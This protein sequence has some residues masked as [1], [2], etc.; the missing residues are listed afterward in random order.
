MERFLHLTPVFWSIYFDICSCTLIKN[1][2]G[3]VFHNWPFCSTEV[4][5]N[6]EES[7]PL[8]Q[9]DA[10]NKKLLPLWIKQYFSWRADIALSLVFYLR[11]CSSGLMKMDFKSEHKTSDQP[12]SYISWF[13][14]H[15]GHIRHSVF[16]CKS[17]GTTVR[18]WD[19]FRFSLCATI[20]F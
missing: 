13:S 3:W 2:P 12:R 16:Y 15:C 5:Q 11:K 4:K 17:T 7:S 20:M 14:P 1:A 18:L 6:P 9:I 10:S 19:F 8:H